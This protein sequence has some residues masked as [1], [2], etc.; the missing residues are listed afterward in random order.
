VKVIVSLVTAL[1]LAAYLANGAR[2]RH[3]VAA[4]DGTAPLSPAS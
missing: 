2:F 1:L 3:E 4:P